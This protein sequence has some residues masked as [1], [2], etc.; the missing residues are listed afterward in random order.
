M[1]KSVFIAIP[2]KPNT[3]ECENH[4]TTS[5]ISHTLKLMLKKILR[6]IRRKLL[7]VYT[8]TSLSIWFHAGQ[9]HKKCNLC[10]THACEGSIKHQRDVFLCFIDYQKA[11]DKVHHLQLLTILKQIDIDHK[12]FRIMRN[13]L[14]CEQKPVIKLM[15][16]LTGW[17]DIK[18]D[19]RQG[20]VMS[21]DLFN[22]Y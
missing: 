3:L 20:C 1:L 19:V 2:K 22:L 9:R 17:T 18:R 16:A 6:C 7:P 14:Y 4:R 21:L 11:F 15:E 5:L 12:H 8:N 13:N 10:D